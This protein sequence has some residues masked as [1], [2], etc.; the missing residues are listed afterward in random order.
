MNINANGLAAET[1]E[2]VFNYMSASTEPSLLRNGQ[3]MIRR[4][5]D[6]NT[7]D[8]NGFDLETRTLP[9]HNARLMHPDARPTCDKNGFE[10]LLHPLPPGPLDFTD[11]AQ[12]VD[13]Y[14]SQCAAIVAQATGAR[15]Y[16]FD[17]NVRSARGKKNN[18]R[19]TGGQ[20]VQGPAHVV[21]GD[22]TLRAAPER[23]NQLAKPPSGND[24]LLGVLDTGKSL[25]SSPDAS[26]A[27]AD[28]GRFAIINVWRNI[29]SEPVAT[30]PL[31]LC[32]G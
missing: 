22:Y 30:H 25:I 31:A 3:V 15:A 20:N 7:A 32:D 2:G 10:L 16:A 5:P 19:I 18:Q 8:S 23:L 6:G 4:D 14:Y 21:H 24:T 27:L 26:H 17:H 11:H 13:D 1:C 9:V 28:G 29:D 12:V